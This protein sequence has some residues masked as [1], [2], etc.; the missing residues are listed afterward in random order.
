MP[1]ARIDA[2]KVGPF[3][4]TLPSEVARELAVKDPWPKVLAIE[5]SGNEFKLAIRDSK[6][7]CNPD[8]DYS[9]TR[10]ALFV[11]GTAIHVVY[12]ETCSVLDP[13]STDAIVNALRKPFP[14]PSSPRSIRRKEY[15][16]G[17]RGREIDGIPSGTL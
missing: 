10:I 1:S 7:E 9:S 3:Q 11:N 16:D 13:L 4:V 14:K 5:R 6:H 8:D 2:S 17:I 12:C 15:P